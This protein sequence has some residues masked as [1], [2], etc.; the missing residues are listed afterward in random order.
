MGKKQKNLTFLLI[1][2]GLVFLIYGSSLGGSFVFD[3]RSIVNHQNI[4]SDLNNLP[5]VLI[6]GYWTPEAGLYRPITLV[7]YLFNYSFLGSGAGNFH[8]INL[9]LYALTG[10]LLF[11]LISKLFLK[12][13]WLAYLTSLLFLVLPIHSEVVANIVGRA[14]ILALFFSL[15]FFLELVKKESNPWKAGFWMLLAIGSK[16]TAIAALPIALFI[17]FYKSRARI[18]RKIIV[19]YLPHALISGLAALVYFVARW[20]VLNQYFMMANASLV[21]NPLKFASGSERVATGFK[22]LFIYFKKTFWPI[23]LCSDYSYNQI[24]VL[25]SFLNLESILGLLILLFFVLGMIFFLGCWPVLALGSAFFIF[26]Y[27]PISNLIFPIGTIA[28]ERLIYFASVGLCLYLASALLL[29]CRFKSKIFRLIFL[30]LIIGLLVFYGGVS[31]TRSLD[32]LTEKSLFISAAQCAPNSVLSR[33]DLATVFYFERKYDL[34]EQEALAANQIYDKYSKG[35]NNL[36]LIHWKKGEYQK[37]KQQY[38]KA[39]RNWPPY[40]G[41]YENLFLLYLSQG[42]EEQ[43]IKWLKLFFLDNPES[44]DSYLKSYGLS[45][46]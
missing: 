22:V 10:Y 38:F 35:I 9:I 32:W 45:G 17:V 29:L 2:F 8:L 26:A 44:V 11:R 31:F 13:K 46:R 6:M 12:E 18:N 14:E 16:E 21:E 1:C 3:D 33:S 39:I 40:E 7:S 24:P 36:G 42:Q 5:E 15:L 34:A 23:N 25:T 4:L 27:L 19:D 28:G 43:A 37:A 20:L 41:I 30:I